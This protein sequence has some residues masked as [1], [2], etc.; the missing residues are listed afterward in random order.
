MLTFEKM[1]ELKYGFGLSALKTEDIDADLKASNFLPGANVATCKRRICVAKI[2][3]R[4]LA[5]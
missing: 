1:L 5:A 3:L 4:C 2:V